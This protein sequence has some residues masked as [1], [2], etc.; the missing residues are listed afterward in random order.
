[1]NAVKAHLE[2]ARW[3]LVRAAVAVPEGEA[4]SAT[5]NALAAVQDALDAW[6]TERTQKH[7]EVLADALAAPGGEV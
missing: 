3:A 1:M 5:H 6:E 7:L 4:K 2:D